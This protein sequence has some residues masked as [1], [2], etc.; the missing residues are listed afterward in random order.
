MPPLKHVHCYEWVLDN[1]SLYRCIHPDCTHWRRK[2][3]LRGKRAVCLCGKEF[4]LNH[5]SL[6]LKNPHCNN[7]PLRNNNG[8]PKLN[9]SDEMISAALNEKPKESLEKT[10][11][12]IEIEID[13][14]ELII[15]A[16]DKKPQ[17]IE[18]EKENI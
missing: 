10:P 8:K 17:G 9:T 2:N 15:D 4:I 6:K 1:H 14:F 3:L 16:L 7:C 13:D 12:E 18:E 11:P 5:D